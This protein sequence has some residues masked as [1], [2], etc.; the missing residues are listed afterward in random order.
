MCYSGSA[1]GEVMH[2]YLKI[3]AQIIMTTYML[4]DTRLPL[5]NSV[6]VALHISPAEDAMW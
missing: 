2:L 5:N 4:Y 1:T 3:L 6:C